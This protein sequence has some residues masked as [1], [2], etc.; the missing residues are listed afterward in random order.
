M[1]I[2]G[3]C[4]AQWFKQAMKKRFSAAARENSDTDFQRD[5]GIGEILFRFAASAEGGAKHAG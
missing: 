1:P 3:N 4:V 5:F 2:G